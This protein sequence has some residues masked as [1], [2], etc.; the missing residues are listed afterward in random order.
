MK[1]ISSHTINKDNEY[2]L[3]GHMKGRDG[4]YGRVTFRNCGYEEFYL[5]A[6]NVLYCTE[7][8]I[9]LSFTRLHGVI[10]QKIEHD[11]VTYENLKSGIIQL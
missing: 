8:E 7:S 11:I 5:L 1:Y 4:I 9:R 10:S 2:R 6:Y 3:L